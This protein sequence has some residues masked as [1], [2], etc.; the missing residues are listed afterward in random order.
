MSCYNKNRSA[1]DPGSSS[2]HMNN[3]LSPIW[4]VQILHQFPPVKVSALSPQKLF[5]IIFCKY[6]V[7]GLLC[8]WRT[9]PLPKAPFPPEKRK[10]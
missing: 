9:L 10:R 6:G 1:A 8:S 3:H 7:V 4:K 2:C 5:T